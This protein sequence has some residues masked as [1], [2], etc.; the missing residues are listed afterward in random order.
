MPNRRSR[1]TIGSDAAA[2]RRDL[3]LFDLA[4]SGGIDLDDLPHRRL[5]HR[6]GRSPTRAISASVIESVSGSSMAKRVPSP[7]AVSSDIVPL[8]SLDRRL[9]HRHADAAAAGAV[10]L[11]AGREPG[12]ADDVEQFAPAERPVGHRHARRA[13]ARRPPRCDVDAAPIVG[14]L[15]A[16]TGRRRSTH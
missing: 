2:Q 10:G 11:V 16:C 15:D 1:R 8:S 9:D 6:E 4:Q 7:G 13:R 12:R 14:N 3:V 5:R